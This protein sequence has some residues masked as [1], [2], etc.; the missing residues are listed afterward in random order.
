MMTKGARDAEASRAFGI[1]F[2]LFN[3]VLTF[4]YN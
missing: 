4:I 1:L 2:Y 3:M